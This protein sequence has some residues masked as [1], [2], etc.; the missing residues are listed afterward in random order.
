MNYKRSHSTHTSYSVLILFLQ[1]IYTSPVYE[2][3]STKK[4][5]WSSAGLACNKLQKPTDVKAKA[6]A[7][8]FSSSS[9][10][11]SVPAFDP[12]KEAVNQSDQKKKKKGSIS[13]GRAV[14][15]T[16]VLSHR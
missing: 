1:L 10:K 3:Y 4:Q 8:L 6:L 9:Q 13:Q 15:V 12:S 11:C 7:K 16:L 2:V 14:N 5:A